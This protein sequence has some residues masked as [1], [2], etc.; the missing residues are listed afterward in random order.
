[1]PDF[2]RSPLSLASVARESGRKAKSKET[3]FKVESWFVLSQPQPLSA[4]QQAQAHGCGGWWVKVER[5]G[6]SRRT[7]AAPDWGAVRQDVRRAQSSRSPS[8][9]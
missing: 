4:S 3:C 5:N 8:G 2:L 9:P 6:R 1:M 7:Y